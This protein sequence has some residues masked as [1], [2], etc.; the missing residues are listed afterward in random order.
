MNQI[1]KIENQINHGAKYL[2][3]SDSSIYK[4][5][6]IEPFMHDYVGSYENIDIFNLQKTR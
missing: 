2:L 3:V 4:D 1:E 6:S 5:A